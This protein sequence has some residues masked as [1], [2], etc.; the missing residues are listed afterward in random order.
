[1]DKFDDAYWAKVESRIK[2]CKNCGNSVTKDKHSSTGWTHRGDW[3]GIRCQ[4]MLCG[5]EPAT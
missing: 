3:V 5:A 1:M 4:N 2:S